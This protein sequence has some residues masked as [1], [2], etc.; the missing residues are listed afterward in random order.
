MYLLERANTRP[1]T[2]C[3]HT[4]DGGIT[5]VTLND[6][7]VKTWAYGIPICSTILQNL[8]E[9]RDVDPA[10]SQLH[11]KE[12][13]MGHITSDGKDR[14]SLREKLELCIYPLDPERHP[15]DGLVNILT[16]EVLYHPSQLK[17]DMKVEPFSATRNPPCTRR[18]T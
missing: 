8:D 10:P 1:F 13:G 11:H 15:R 18:A 2:T 9:M 17:N 4:H 5:G 3:T 6:E 14:L 7:C 12:E 16:G